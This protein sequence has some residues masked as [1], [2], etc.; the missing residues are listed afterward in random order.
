MLI[1][2][3]PSFVEDRSVHRNP[4]ESAPISYR[5]VLILTG[6]VILLIVVIPIIWENQVRISQLFTQMRNLVVIKSPG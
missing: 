6:L 2:I 3:R 1:A 5:R 4:L